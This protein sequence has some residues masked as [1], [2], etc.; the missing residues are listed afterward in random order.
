MNESLEIGQMPKH[1]TKGFTSRILVKVDHG[2]DL[3]IITQLQR[4]CMMK[5]NMLINARIKMDWFR[6]NTEGNLVTNTIDLMKI[7]KTA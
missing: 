1:W 6:V 5:D 4:P 7:A 3:A 2:S